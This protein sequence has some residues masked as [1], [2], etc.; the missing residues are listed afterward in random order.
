MPTL[1]LPTVVPAVQTLE[2]AQ[3]PP[4]KE[5][6]R[7]CE[8]EPSSFNQVDDGTWRLHSTTASW[9]FNP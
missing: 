4:A 3:L 7:P 2:D 5:K 8:V 9:V 1:H 6:L